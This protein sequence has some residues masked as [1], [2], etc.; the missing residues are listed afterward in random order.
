MEMY[1]NISD[2]FGEV[3]KRGFRLHLPREEERTI[4]TPSDQHNAK[5]GKSIAFRGGTEVRLGRRSGGS[6]LDI[7]W[8]SL[9]IELSTLSSAVSHSLAWPKISRFGHCRGVMKR[10]ETSCVQPPR[11][12]AQDKAARGLVLF[13]P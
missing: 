13:Y 5:Y 8:R 3:E 1:F 10:R 11:R 2:P 7:V 6:F 12:M 4:W 9:Y